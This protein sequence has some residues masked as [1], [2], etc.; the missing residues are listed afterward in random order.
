MSNAK[1]KFFNKEK[2]WGFL[3]LTENKERVF[4]HYKAL[5]YENCNQDDKVTCD[6]IKSEHKPGTLCAVNIQIS[7]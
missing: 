1:V 4:F 6:V 2:G 7:E 5:N 3:E